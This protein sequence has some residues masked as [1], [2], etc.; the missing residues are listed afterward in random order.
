[1]IGMSLRVA[2]SWLVLVGSLALAVPAGMNVRFGL[3]ENYSW[4]LQAALTSP[5]RAEDAAAT[6]RGAPDIL[7]AAACHAGSNRLLLKIGFVNPP[8]FKNSSF[9]VYLDLDNDPNTGR[10]D[11]QHRGVDVMV[12][13][14]GDSVHAGARNPDYGQTKVAAWVEGK[15][16]W[17]ALDARL[18]VA[19][20]EVVFG[21]HLLAQRAGGA[22]DST[23]HAVVRLPVGKE[24]KLTAGQLGRSGS[25]RSLSDYRFHDDKVKLL[26]LSDKGLS[27]KDVAPSQPLV[28][29]P[30]PPLPL[31]RPAPVI[32]GNLGS[33]KFRE[34]PVEVLEEA[35]VARSPAWL[36]FGL[37]LA[38]GAL[39]SPAWIAVLGPDGKQ[40]PAQTATAGRWPDGSLRWVRVNC[41]LPLKANEKAICRIQFGSD[42][43]PSSATPLAVVRADGLLTVTDGTSRFAINTKE[44]GLLQS[45]VIDGRKSG[46]FSPEGVILVDG[47]GTQ[48]TTAGVPPSSVRIEEW[49]P[50]QVVVRVAGDYA[51]AKGT[52]YMSYISRLTFRQ[53]SSRV[54][55]AHT[56]INS[57]TATEFTEVQSLGLR[58]QGA[59][60]F[61]SL[62]AK[63]EGKEPWASDTALT[64]WTADIVA[65]VLPPTLFPSRLTGA[66]MA[67]GKQPVGLALR[68]LWQRWPKGFRVADGTLQVSLLPKLPPGASGKGLPHYLRYPFADG[69]YRMKWGMAFTEEM[70]VD[71]AGGGSA[72]EMSAETDLPV[73]A[74]LPAAYYAE[75]KAAGMLAAP[76]AKQFA[77][78]DAFVAAGFARHMARKRQYRE[79]G[80][81]NYGDWYGERG[82]NWGNNEYDLA[83]G[84]FRQFL[85]TG[86][87]AYCRWAQTAARHQADV[88]C[89]HAYPDPAYVGSNH[90]HSIGHTG[91][92]SDRPKR[93]TWTH[94]YDS[95]TSAENGHTWAEGMV[96]SWWLTGDP[97]AME[98]AIGLGEHIAWA[99]APRFRRLGT[100]E[101]SAGWSLKAILAVHAARPDPEYLAAAKRIAA[102]ALR[103]QKL[104]QGGAWPH[105]LPVDHAGGHHGA[106]GNNLFLLGV[107]LE[108]LKNYHEATGDPATE[109][110]LIAG[111]DWVLKS[112]D[113]KVG[114]WPY[115]AS[116]TG[117]PFYP[118]KT[119][120]NLLV[121]DP[122]AY[123]GKLTGRKDCYEV[124][125]NALSAVLIDR[126]PANGKS[127]AQRLV[128]ADTIL[129]LL[130]EHFAATDPQRGLD[131][132]SDDG[133]M[134]ALVRTPDAAAFN[135]RSP[136]VKV[137]HVQTTGD[138]PVLTGARKPHGSRPKGMA[139]GTL[140]VTDAAG[141]EV[142]RKEF[143][144]DHP[145]DCRIPLPKTKGQIYRVVVT[146]DERSA[147]SLAGDG[148]QVVAEVVKGFSLG[149]VG[150]ARYHFLVPPDCSGFSVRIEGVHT[151]EF[152]G[153]VVDPDGKIIAMHRGTND[154]KTRLTW[155]AEEKQAATK[156]PVATLKVQPSAA[157][158]GKVWDLLLWARMDIRCD[159]KGLPPILSC[160]KD[161]WFQPKQK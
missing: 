32:A 131:L 117:A 68:D 36:S 74:V 11:K 152:G 97:R 44:F 63:L 112:F 111:V 145:L 31:E 30:R 102:V 96:D 99:M 4:P 24:S 87:R 135:L 86:N 122:I 52:R 161:D 59:A 78:W 75:T 9:I 147:W 128:N 123:V 156:A 94:R 149:G 90:Q 65:S 55:I 51:D 80:F 143:S 57:Y 98:S 10:V 3:P 107:L 43:K 81:F 91:T 42:V 155:A 100:H 134:D 89:V 34:I 50:L 84:L 79:Y 130:Q 19:G 61:T 12:S 93:A 33:V 17:L 160:R 16:F 153:A 106:K 72:A 20:Q 139:T 116:E 18:K 77:H 5:P 146:D 6:E 115:S 103:E 150:R 144:T 8:Q 14:S 138:T 101:R 28:L 154:G 124:V 76:V 54:G 46:G 70:T 159:L 110:A 142:A 82:R 125:A 157:A 49:G 121:I 23:S 73:I 7:S 126:P 133:F 47:Q 69:L 129:A 118:A 39:Y 48:F 53:G 21:M 60:P 66:I 132:L 64:Q 109:R 40:L 2:V 35:G 140:V 92:W 113:P 95:H 22:S 37:P 104:D 67:E 83:H 29:R 62:G 114:G 119:G 38:K 136:T 158:R 151:G 137:F 71:F 58:L 120:L 88:D 85:R 1:M 25:L 108:G 41:R 141:K 15:D 45:A 26:S 148:L 105:L 56:N 27:A 127:L 13:V